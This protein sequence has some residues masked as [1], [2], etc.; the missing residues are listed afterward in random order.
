VSGEAFTL[1]AVPLSTGM[2]IALF[3]IGFFAQLVDGAVGMGYGLTS[4]SL[5]LFLG[6]PP[7][8]ASASVHTAEIFT[9]GASG[10]SHGF[11][12]NVDWRL[13]ARLA[14]P[15]VCGGVIGA[16][17]LSVIQS[18]WLK[19]VVALY[20]C[21]LGSFILWRTLRPAVSTGQTVRPT[22][23]GLVSGFLDAIGG[24]GW[25]PLTSGTLIA[26][27]H[28]P[29]IAI[30]SASAAEFFV[31]LAIAA[32]LFHALGAVPLQWIACVVGGGVLAAPL[33]AYIARFMPVRPARIAVGAFLVVISLVTLSTVR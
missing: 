15:G 18:P 7:Q 16:T 3:A 14:V 19:P 25:S 33:A 24:G 5:L 12:G 28:E 10:L 23:L 13:V 26:D 32:V 4:S 21:A 29:R 2:L 8:A 9:T 1:A 20:L 6:V 31:T 30:G 11:V 17:L 27:Q 22:R